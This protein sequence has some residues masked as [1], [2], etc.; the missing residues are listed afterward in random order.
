MHPIESHPMILCTRP[1][2]T[3]G[4]YHR[5]FSFWK[6]FWRI[7]SPWIV[8]MWPDYGSARCAF[9]ASLIDGRGVDVLPPG[10]SCLSVSSPRP[11]WWLRPGVWSVVYSGVILLLWCWRWP[12]SAISARHHSQRTGKARCCSSSPLT[13]MSSKTFLLLLQRSKSFFLCG[14]RELS[15]CIAWW[16]SSYFSFL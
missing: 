8:N 5:D 3:V 2:Q 9:S 15:L 16:P 6:L 7:A 13:Y 10:S 11:P 1:G 14:W 4:Q 12:A